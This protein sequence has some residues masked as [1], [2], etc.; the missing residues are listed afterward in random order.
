MLSKIKR[1]AYLIILTVLALTLPAAVSAQSPTPTSSPTSTPISIGTEIVPG[2][3]APINNILIIVQAVVRF[4]L[5]IAFVVAF[6]ILLVGGVRWIISGGDEKAV[7]SARNT[8]T[9]ALIGLVI[10]LI[11]YAII[12]VVEV[13]FNLNIVTGGVTIPTVVGP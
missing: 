13:F 7:G 10:V 8:I 6:I 3:I 11:A 12:R 4:I 9:G 2:N 1:L 5:V